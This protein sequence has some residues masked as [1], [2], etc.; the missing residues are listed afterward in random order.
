MCHRAIFSLD[1]IDTSIPLIYYI[2][3]VNI[4]ARDGKNTHRLKYPRVLDP[5]GA[6]MGTSNRGWH[7]LGIFKISWIQVS[8]FSPG[9]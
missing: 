7:M 1:A 5:I 8:G 9:T 2:F 4:L 6:N 3:L